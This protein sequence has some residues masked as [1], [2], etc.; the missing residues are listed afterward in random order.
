MP[1]DAK[2]ITDSVVQLWNTGNTDVAEQIYSK[3]AQWHDPGRPEPIRGSQQIAQ[4]VTY[5]RTAYPDFK[6]EVNESMQDGDRLATHW[7]VTGT[8]RGEFQGIPPTGKQINIKGM[9][10]TRIENGQIT[11]EHVYFDRLAM[12]EQLGVAPGAGQAQALRA[13]S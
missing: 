6:L 5:V 7:T 8:Q 11:E 12:M 4:Y 3:N 1:Q 10:L 13:A 9:T 2:A